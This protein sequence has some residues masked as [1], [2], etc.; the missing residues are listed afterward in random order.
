MWDGK[1]SSQSSV[2]SEEKNVGAGRIKLVGNRQLDVGATPCVCPCGLAGEMIRQ[3]ACCSGEK[4]FASSTEKLISMHELLADLLHIPSFPQNHI[5]F[6]KT[7]EKN[8]E[9]LIMLFLKRE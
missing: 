7:L 6:R 1:R 8:T 3:Q 2:L 9:S 5:F 4:S